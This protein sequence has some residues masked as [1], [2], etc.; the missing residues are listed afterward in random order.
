MKVGIRRCLFTWLTQ[1]LMC[2]QQI[3]YAEQHLPLYSIRPRD[4]FA[5]TTVLST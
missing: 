1:E 3:R 5:I 4:S 2:V